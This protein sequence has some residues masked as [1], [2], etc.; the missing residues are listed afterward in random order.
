MKIK[1]TTKDSTIRTLIALKQDIYERAN[2]RA[3]DLQR[4]R[5]DLDKRGDILKAIH[6]RADIEA[7]KIAYA[8]QLVRVR[9]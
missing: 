8:I 5:G 7:S 4:N 6:R 3:D 1:A 9:A 2:K